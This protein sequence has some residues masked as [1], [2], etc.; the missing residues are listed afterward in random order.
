MKIRL[1]RFGGGW[2]STYMITTVSNMKK[3]HAYKYALQ[4]AHMYKILKFH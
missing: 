3:A 1:D 4:I 2:D